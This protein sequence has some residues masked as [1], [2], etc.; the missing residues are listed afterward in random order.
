M[1][2]R[3]EHTPGEAALAAGTYEQLNILGR[4][5]GIRAVLTRGDPLPNAPVGHVWR[6]IDE[7]AASEQ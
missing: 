6:L 5:T 1:T 3:H 7:D 4:S 2:R